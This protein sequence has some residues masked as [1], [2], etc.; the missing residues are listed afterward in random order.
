M[1]G[2]AESGLILGGG[3]MEEGEI[4]LEPVR[5]WA[6]F[7]AFEA[8]YSRTRI[9]RSTVSKESGVQG[10]A[11]LFLYERDR[12][13][14]RHSVGDGPSDGLPDVAEP[15]SDRDHVWRN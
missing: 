4:L 11:A 13:C 8:A 7:Y 12:G 10:A 15:N 14:P 9:V 6:G 1:S 5:R 3:V 2:S